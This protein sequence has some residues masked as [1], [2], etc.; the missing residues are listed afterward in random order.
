MNKKR[1]CQIGNIVAAL[2]LGLGAVA[3]IWA[4]L[5]IYNSGGSQI[6]TPKKIGFYFSRIAWIVYI[7]LALVTANC[8]LQ[9]MLSE[10]KSRSREK[11]YPML[12]K[13]WHSRHPVSSCENT[14]L[15]A[16]IGAQQRRRKM[17]TWVN[18]G[19]LGLGTVIFLCYALRPAAYHQTQI[20]DSMISAMWVLLPCMGV[21]FVL[22]AVTAYLNRKSM[23]KELELLK[24]VPA[25]QP[26]T[27]PA[28]ENKTLLYVRLG[29]AAVAVAFIVCGF[30]FG[31]W[32]DVLTK[33]V[34]IC[35]ECVGLG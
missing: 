20:T 33:A 19:V 16:A 7:A 25:G 28:E 2:A 15:V 5:C 17:L 22:A 10:K 29:L 23:E 32:L 8:V 26:Q 11:N 13:L 1:V 30:A 24:Q 21:P 4:C 12:L 6:Y 9:F 31:G 3:L 27:A 34:N 18:L 14:Q 35:T